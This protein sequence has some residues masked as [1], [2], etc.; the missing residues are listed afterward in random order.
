VKVFMNIKVVVYHVHDTFKN[1]IGFVKW[2]LNMEWSVNKLHI[3]SVL[4]PS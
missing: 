2:F 4:I 1:A 3:L